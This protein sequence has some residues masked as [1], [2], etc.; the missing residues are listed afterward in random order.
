MNDDISTSSLPPKHTD[1]VIN[2]NLMIQA[3]N[4]CT[5]CSEIWESFRHNLWIIFL[6]RRQRFLIMQA[7]SFVKKLPNEKQWSSTLFSWLNFWF[8]LMRRLH[9]KT[10]PSLT[11]SQLC[12]VTSAHW[13]K[14]KKTFF[15]I[16]ILMPLFSPSSSIRRSCYIITIGA[17]AH[18]S[19]PWAIY[20]EK[21]TW[22]TQTDRQTDH[23][24]CVGKTKSQTIDNRPG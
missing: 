9:K 13:N 12:P 19:S 22:R 4:N 20:R 14:I 18:K 11:I 17:I 21:Q 5:G 6:N 24:W 23:C 16:F 10:H 3:I 1:F 8:S 15:F 7:S 2:N